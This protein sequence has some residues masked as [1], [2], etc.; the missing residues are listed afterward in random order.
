MAQP[1]ATKVVSEDG[2]L[3]VD[4]RLHQI[5]TD[6][7][8]VNSHFRP[9]TG[10]VIPLR[11]TI[12]RDAQTSALTIYSPIP[13]SMHDDVST[14]GT[15]KAII[16]PA[17]FHSSYAQIALDHFPNA[18]L[19]STPALPKR[20]PQKNWGTI[21][22]VDTP[23]DCIGP[24]VHMFL[25]NHHPFMREVVLLHRSTGTLV[26]S[27][28][29]F[30]FTPSV[31]VHTSFLSRLYVFITDSRRPL[32]TSA[33]LRFMLAS[34]G[35]RTLTALEALLQLPWDR[36]VPCHGQVVDVG[37]KQLFKDELYS[38]VKNKVRAQPSNLLR[39]LAFVAL[40]IASVALLL[41]NRDRM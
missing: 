2:K 1:S 16:A 30:N 12:V 26:F 14:L 28:L 15:V 21:V 13:P 25:L 6:I 17:A 38:S 31:L 36:A 3:T 35:E 32:S 8:A 33:P 34:G 22:T 18:T 29:A 7:F 4:P 20:K 23:P 41:R 37:A 5:T 39:K 11:T 40:F 10:M 24:D 27:D 9:Y 19:Y